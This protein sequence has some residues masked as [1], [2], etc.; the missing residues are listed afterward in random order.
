MYVAIASPYPRDRGVTEWYQS[1]GSYL[2]GNHLGQCSGSYQ[3]YNQVQLEL[4][5]I[6]TWKFQLQV[7]EYLSP[8]IIPSLSPNIPYFHN[9]NLIANLI[10]N[11]IS[12]LISDFSDF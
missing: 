2:M 5:C 3:Q 6:W 10:S 7:Q 9:Q 1:L 12:K 8:L 11:Q 4:I